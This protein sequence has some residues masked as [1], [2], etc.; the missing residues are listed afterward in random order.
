MISPSRFCTLILITFNIHSS[1][2]DTILNRAVPIETHLGSERDV[3]R[4]EEANMDIMTSFEDEDVD[5]EHET[6]EDDNNKTDS[7]DEND[8]DIVIVIFSYDY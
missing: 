5:I 2:R 6:E 8:E 4:A 3:A 1:L 7:D